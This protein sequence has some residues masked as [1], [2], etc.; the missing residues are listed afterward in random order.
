MKETP[1]S[2]CEWATYSNSPLMIHYHDK[3]WGVPVHN[4]RILFEF[5]TLEGAQAGL[6]WQTI[7]NKRE[8]YRKAFH[9]FDPAKIARYNKKDVQRLLHDSGIIRN[10][11]K[12][13]ATITNAKQFLETRKE[14]GSFDGYMWRFVGG[15]PIRNA[16]KSLSEIPSTTRESDAMSK[17]LRKRGFRFVGPTICY[18][19]MQ[20]VGMVNDH[21][22]KCFRYNR[23]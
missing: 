8:N 5:L 4:D 19:F 3:E 22:T 10:R 12:I 23:V 18:A 16:A 20:A 7:L 17:E 1:A 13:E 11:L 21:T 15:R 14:F 6:N 2:R 9:A